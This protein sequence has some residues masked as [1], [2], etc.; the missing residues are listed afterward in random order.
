M[1]SE[2]FITNPATEEQIGP[3]KRYNLEELKAL[4]AK[5]RQAQEKWRDVPLTERIALMEKF[6]VEFENRRDKIARDITAQMGKTLAQSNNE[7]NGMIFR[8]RGCIDQAQE[9]LAPRRLKDVDNFERYVERI[10]H[11][12]ILNMAAWNYPLMIAINVIAPAILAG[13]SVI[14]KHSAKT[15]LCGDIF[16][17][18]FEAVGAPENLV[19]AVQGDHQT[20]Q[21]LI[22]SDA[23]D[24][25]AFTG[26]VEGG[27]Q[28]RIAARERFIEVGLELGGKDPAYVM[29]EQDDLDWTAANLA[30]A[31]I[32][33]CGQSCCAVERIYVHE[34][35]YDEFLP[36][37]LEHA[38]SY[39]PSDPLDENS[40][41]GPMVSASARK[42]IES[43]VADAKQNGA[44]VALEGGATDVN[45]KGF[46][47]SPTVLT[48]VNHD[49]KI[50]SEENFGP[51]MGIMKVKDDEEALKL[52]NDSKY[53]LTASVWGKDQARIE[54]MLSRLMAGTVFMN[55]C[56]FLDPELPWTGY[57]DSGLGSTLGHEGFGHLTRP[58]SVHKRLKAG[59]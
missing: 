13:N 45:G 47:Y 41:L 28:V 11:G 42:Y 27:R 17:E 40:N 9:A 3:I 10:P 32:Y 18:V 52:M 48:G 22:A 7:I 21:D 5:S 38:K 16:Q 57:G 31:F 44:Q 43:Q 49:M 29:E 55:R 6:L 15:P 30:E 50:M 35:I 33:N 36:R 39:S 14:I 25:V 58:R 34:K 23:V 54:K 4:A 20:M 24:Y 46:F 8:T 53:G 19:I 12:V 1:S 37:F 59:V 51:I 56:D 2:F 26:S